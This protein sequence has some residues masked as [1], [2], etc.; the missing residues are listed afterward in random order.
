MRWACRGISI[1]MA[2]VYHAVW[3]MMY[4]LGVGYLGEKH[5]V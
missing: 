4:R 2:E 1:E 5:G 3:F